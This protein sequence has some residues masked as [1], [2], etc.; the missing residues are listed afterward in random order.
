[1]SWLTDLWHWVSTPIQVAAPIWVLTATV[2]GAGLAATPAVWKLTRLFATYVHEAGHAVIAVLTGRRVTKI[3]LE[4]DTSGT[5]EHVGE[6]YGIGRLLTAFAGYPAPALAGWGVIAAILHGYPRWAI[7]G[8]GLLALLLA[9]VQRSW[10]GWLITLIMLGGVW[11]LAPFSDSIPSVVLALIAG[12]LLM[13]SPR[14]V[15]EL[16]LLRRRHLREMGE[17]HSDADSL[18]SHT[19]IPAGFWEVLFLAACGWVWW[20]VVQQFMAIL[21]T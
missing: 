9:L 12:Y 21:A 16:H 17:V 20:L 5:T 7:A 8:F 2:L 6:R 3:R 1:M 4:A 19:G 13:A 14:T 10:R 18:A 15:V 11:L